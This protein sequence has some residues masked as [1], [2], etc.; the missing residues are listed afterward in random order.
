MAGCSEVLI[1]TVAMRILVR[2][3]PFGGGFVLCLE[4]AAYVD[5]SSSWLM[6]WTFQSSLDA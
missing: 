5:L 3:A 2:G 6:Y 1:P 4:P